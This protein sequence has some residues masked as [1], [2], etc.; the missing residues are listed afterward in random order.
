MGKRSATRASSAVEA[1]V[2]C[3]I[4]YLPWI[5]S[6]ACLAGA[7]MFPAYSTPIWIAGVAS[8][9]PLLWSEL[10]KP[11]NYVSLTFDAAGF[12]FRGSPNSEVIV[13]WSE[14]REVFYCRTFNDFANCI[15]TEWQFMLNDGRLVTVLVEWPQR[16]K[17]ADAIGKNLSLVSADAVK[18]AM[19]QTQEGR[20]SVVAEAGRA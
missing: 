5:V 8:L 13:R 16:S 15:E 19:R 17:F 2:L 20:W 10:R 4:D 6:G 11:V 14:V 7:W 12:A 18:R 3:P 9:T 1:I